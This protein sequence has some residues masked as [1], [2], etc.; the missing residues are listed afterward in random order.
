MDDSLLDGYRP[1]KRGC[2]NVIFYMGFAMGR[3]PY[4]WGKYAQEFRP[5][6]MARQWNFST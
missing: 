2:E 6:K 1:K 5:E 3:M 4:I